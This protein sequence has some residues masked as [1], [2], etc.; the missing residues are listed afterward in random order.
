MS[1]SKDTGTAVDPGPRPDRRARRRLETIDEI[2]AIARDVMTEEG[3]N[4]LS[5]AEGARRPGGQPPSLY[6]Y[7]PSLLAVYDELFA[8]GQAENLAVMR[9]GMQGAAPGLD[10]LVAGLEASGRWALDNPAAAG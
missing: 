9:A 6:K 8:R 7:F 10:A 4:G 5:P 3:G 1:M 2:L